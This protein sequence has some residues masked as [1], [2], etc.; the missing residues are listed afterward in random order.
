[1][2]LA[3]AAPAAVASL[4]YL[5]ARTQFSADYN[6]L[7]ALIAST[8]QTSIL[9]KRDRVNLFYT[10]EQHATAKKTENATCVVYEGR[11]WTYKEFYD[12]VLKYAAWLKQR[13]SIAPKE[14][15]AMDFMNSPQFLFLWLALWSLGAHPA[16]I[17]YNLTG[18]PLLHCIR[19]STS[20]IVFVDVEIKSNF[21]S[22]VAD[23][24][25]SQDF[26]DGKGPVEVVF[27]DHEIEQQI[28]STEGH[29]EPDSSRSGAVGHGMANLIY[30]SGTTGLPKP[31]IVSWNKGHVG[32]GFV[33]RWASIKRTDRFYTVSSTST[34]PCPVSYALCAT[35][36]ASIAVH[37]SIPLLG[38]YSRV[39][40][41]S[42]GWQH[43]HFRPQ[44]QHTHFLARSAGQQRHHNPIRRR[45]LSVPPS[46]SPSNRSGYRRES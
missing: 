34:L 22:E 27:F 32:G 37:A 38:S 1:M 3:V 35:S 17:N 25:A 40:L 30:T 43:L 42:W 12:T 44:I 19:V 45:D 16:F 41:M 18:N 8:V 11:S 39:L 9:E 10:L 26:R 20:R 36:N 14:I 24:V 23:A 2:P 33:S 15:V 6:L 7:Y 5:N 31:A 4:A 13:Y 21:T 29:R 46:S 28:L